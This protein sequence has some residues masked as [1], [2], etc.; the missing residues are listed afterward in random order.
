MDKRGDYHLREDI[1]K[2]CSVDHLEDDVASFRD[3][4]I[5]DVFLDEIGKEKDKEDA[6]RGIKQ[7][8]FLVAP[9]AKEHDKA[10]EEKE[11][12]N[13]H[14]LD[15]RELVESGHHR[16]WTCHGTD[17]IANGTDRG[18]EA[19]EELKLRNAGKKDTGLGKV[20][21][22]ADFDGIDRL[23]VDGIIGKLDGTIDAKRK[24][25]DEDDRKGDA[26]LHQRN[27]QKGKD[28][29]DADDEEAI[30][31]MIHNGA[32]FSMK[33]Q[34]RKDGK[35]NHESPTIQNGDSEMK[36]GKRKERK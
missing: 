12:M 24:G 30:R 4:G 21:D 8:P 10:A 6:C 26:S 7:C 5:E 31:H 17:E 3:A 27:G 9:Y 19:G 13:Y 35:E 32:P 1:A 16:V 28:K 14:A 22:M 20:G 36:Y 25:D 2:Q 15:D 18:K 29:E 33:A 23:A 11:T 34:K